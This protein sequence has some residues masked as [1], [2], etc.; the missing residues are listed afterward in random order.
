MLSGVAVSRRERRQIGESGPG[1]ARTERVFN[2]VHL[3]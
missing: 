2:N 1:Y 3:L